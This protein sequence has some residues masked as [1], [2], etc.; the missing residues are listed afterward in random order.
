M[1][2]RLTVEERMR[3]TDLVYRAVVSLVQSLIQEGAREIAGHTTLADGV[4]VRIKSVSVSRSELEQSLFQISVDSQHLVEGEPVIDVSIFPVTSRGSNEHGRFGQS[5][6]KFDHLPESDLLL[7]V[8]PRQ[9]IREPD[10]VFGAGA[11]RVEVRYVGIFPPISLQDDRA[12]A[13]Y[14]LLKTIGW[15]EQ[16]PIAR[17]LAAMAPDVFIHLYNIIGDQ[18]LS[19]KERG[20]LALASYLLPYGQYLAVREAGVKVYA[21]L[22]VP[23]GIQ[24]WACDI[25]VSL[26]AEPEMRILGEEILSEMGGVK[27]AVGGRS[28]DRTRLL[29]DAPRVLEI[30]REIQGEYTRARQLGKEKPARE[31]AREAVRMGIEWLLDARAAIPIT[32]AIIPADM[33]GY[34]FPAPVRVA[35]GEREG[36]AVER[37]TDNMQ[38]LMAWLLPASAMRSARRK[39]AQATRPEMDPSALRETAEELVTRMEHGVVSREELVRKICG[40]MDDVVVVLDASGS[41]QP[42]VTFLRTFLEDIR[43]LYPRQLEQWKVVLVNKGIVSVLTAE[44]FARMR[45]VAD[46]LTPLYPAMYVAQELGKEVGI[47]ITDWVHNVDGITYGGRALYVPQPERPAKHVLSLSMLGGVAPLL[48]AESGITMDVSVGRREYLDVLPEIA[49]FAEMIIPRDL[50]IEVTEGEDG[51]LMVFRRE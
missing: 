2:G 18:M 20:A 51:I 36:E 16:S 28:P 42:A 25:W 24:D 10:P 38:D 37:P 23:K 8:R 40:S 26:V 4:L 39:F 22:R 45:I 6:E 13:L 30:V 44:E 33:I 27:G 1:A 14:V 35:T 31:M 12:A 9:G 41:M 11:P 15:N 47:V 29:K 50:S 34:A 5:V 19:S 7:A 49:Q 3:M 43:R 21:G 48:P 46:G 32:A 17:V